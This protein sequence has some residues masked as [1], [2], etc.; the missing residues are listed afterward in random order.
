MKF[1]DI[2][3]SS[4]KVMNVLNAIGAFLLILL[5]CGFILSGLL[6][7]GDLIWLAITDFSVFKNNET[8]AIA[9]FLY[10]LSLIAFF[11]WVIKWVI[12]QRKK[13]TVQEG[14]IFKLNVSTCSCGQTHE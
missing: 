7:D 14:L 4:D 6:L 9:S 13:P 1:I 5:S 8:M 10:C 11:G 12:D 3:K 2:R